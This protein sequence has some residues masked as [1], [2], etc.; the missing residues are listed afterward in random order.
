MMA[1]PNCCINLSP[2]EQGCI[3]GNGGGSEN[4]PKKV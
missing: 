3:S 1:F 2:K 4:R